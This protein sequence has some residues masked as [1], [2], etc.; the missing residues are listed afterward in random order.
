MV[1]FRQ[2]DYLSD[3]QTLEGGGEGTFLSD[4]EKLQEECFHLRI[5]ENSLTS[6]I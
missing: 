6:T 1:S 2:C 4:D 3:S 5:E